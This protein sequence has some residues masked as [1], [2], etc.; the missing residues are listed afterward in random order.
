MASLPWKL[1]NAHKNDSGEQPLIPQNKIRCF[2]F[3][4]HCICLLWRIGFWGGK[5]GTDRLLRHRSLFTRV[6]PEDLCNYLKICLFSQISQSPWSVAYNP[7]T[8]TPSLSLLSGFL[9]LWHLA[10][11]CAFSTKTELMCGAEVRQEPKKMELN[12]LYLLVGKFAGEISTSKW[13]I[14]SPWLIF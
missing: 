4:S 9:L 12:Y 11:M 2:F 8:P 6:T 14:F 10:N 1:S 5:A 3:F 7:P 13:K